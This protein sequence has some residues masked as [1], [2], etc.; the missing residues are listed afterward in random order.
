MTFES[1]Q[2]NNNE[3]TLSFAHKLNEKI[4]WKLTD[5]DRVGLAETEVSSDALLASDG[6]EG[7]PMCRGDCRTLR[8]MADALKLANDFLLSLLLA[9]VTMPATM[10]T[11][12]S[13][14]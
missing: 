13:R 9:W 7:L 8:S 1:D 3:I 10:I 6:L 5:A 11:Y 12:E 4:K 2:C 14:R